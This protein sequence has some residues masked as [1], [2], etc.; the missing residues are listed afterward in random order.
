MI[1][2]GLPFTDTSLLKAPP[3]ALV[4]AQLETFRN[5]GAV[6]VLG[7]RLLAGMH[8]MR[9]VT[10]QQGREVAGL[11]G[12]SSPQNI[13]QET[14]RVLKF[15]NI[16]E[17]QRTLV[18]FEILVSCRAKP[19]TTAE[20]TQ[21]KALPL[22]TIHSPVTSFSTSASP[23]VSIADCPDGLFWCENKAVLDSV[24]LPTTEG[25]EF[26]PFIHLSCLALSFTF[27]HLTSLRSCSF[28]CVK[29]CYLPYLISSPS[30]VL[31]HSPVPSNLCFN[32][33]TPLTPPF[34]TILFYFFSYYFPAMSGMRI[35][36]I[37]SHQSATAAT[38]TSS[39]RALP[40]LQLDQIVILKVEPSLKELYTMLGVLE[41]T[42]SLAVKKFTLPALEK[43]C[44][45]FLQC[46]M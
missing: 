37:G 11:S 9:D 8:A 6:A 1:K 22:F 31:S 45:S 27:S 42:A 23:C 40:A 4:T 7:R 41:L 19:L 39:T 21:L 15:N 36:L 38:S 24:L 16:T 10:L 28:I 35:P 30:Y 14:E 12:V 46:V 29:S 32:F 18:L 5:V 20:M 26:C 34:Y 33:L 25:I 13:L 17:E 44:R 2:L 3:S 43:V